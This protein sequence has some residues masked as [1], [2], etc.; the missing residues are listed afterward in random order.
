MPPAYDGGGALPV[1]INLHGFSSSAEEQ[2]AYSGFP[3][4][5][6]AEGFIVVTP[7]GVGD[8]PFWN[9]VGVALLQDDVAFISDLLDALESQLCIDP[10][11]VYA[12]GISNGAGMSNRLA[13]DLSGRIAAIGTVAGT[14][15]PV[16]CAAPRPVPVIAFHGTAD[17]LVPY[18]GGPINAG[19]SLRLNLQAPP[20]EEAIASWAEHNGCTTGPSRE[21][22]SAHVE[23]IAY[24]GCDAGASVELYAIA[25]GGHT[26]PGASDVP[27]LG[28][29]THEI[30]AT[31]LIWAFFA[32]HPMP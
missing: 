28:A 31:E 9:M 23:R 14:A 6:A 30:S 22:V 17:P 5:G 12:T 32:A 8:P 15:F 16:N 19:L 20:A 26:W 13:C 25:G 11:R 1:V 29:T 27:R 4:K 10:Q 21:S 7:Q 18:A 3:A 24:D 2:A